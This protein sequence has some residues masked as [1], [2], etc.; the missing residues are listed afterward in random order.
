M[1]HAGP[2]ALDRL[3]PFLKQLRAIPA[4]KEKSRGAFYRDGRACL[5]FHEHGGEMW[6]D[7][8]LSGD[9]ERHPPTTGAHRSA[10]LKRLKAALHAR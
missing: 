5:H 2:D 6:A 8:R 1:K 3:E 7:I 4:L 10:L 9:F